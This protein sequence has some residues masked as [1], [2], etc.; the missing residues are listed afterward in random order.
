MVTL[1][2]QGVETEEKRGQ[3]GPSLPAA[4][5]LWGHLP[6]W[7]GH[8]SLQLP[9]ALLAWTRETWEGFPLSVK[10]VIFLISDSSCGV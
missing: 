9:L 5:P 10:P 4:A 6:G 3:D 7:E 1:A 8:A 2:S